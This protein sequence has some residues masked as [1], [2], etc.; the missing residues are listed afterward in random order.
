[1]KHIQGKLA[2]KSHLSPCHMIEQ[3]GKDA[4]PLLE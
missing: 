3:G 4:T 2:E 1:M